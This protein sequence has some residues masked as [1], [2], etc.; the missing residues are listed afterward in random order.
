MY[1]T[2]EDKKVNE[3]LETVFKDNP[4]V[5]TVGIYEKYTRISFVCYLRE[6]IAK[7]PSKDQ[8]DPQYLTKSGHSKIVV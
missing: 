7:C 6:K 3:S 4:E 8:I 2:E 1:E 5:G